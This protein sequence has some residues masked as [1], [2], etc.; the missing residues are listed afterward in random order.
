[1]NYLSYRQ[2]CKSIRLMVYSYWPTPRQRPKRLQWMSMMNG[3]GFAKHTVVSH[4]T[5]LYASHVLR[6]SIY[7]GT[8]QPILGDF[9][10]CMLFIQCKQRKC[11]QQF[12]C[13]GTCRNL[14]ECIP[15][16]CVPPTS[17]AI[18]PARMPPCHTAV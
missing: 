10:I 17:V 11:C 5:C 14:Q 13:M 3:H 12:I 2:N 4:S 16:G 18:S 1:M 8:N 15:V 7:S 9:T 6:M